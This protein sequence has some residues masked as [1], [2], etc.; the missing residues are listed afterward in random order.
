VCAVAA[1]RT[2]VLGLGNPGARYA[3]TRHN[4]GATFVA[5]AALRWRVAL[6]RACTAADYGIGVVAETPVVLAASRTFVNA[7]GDAVRALG[8]T[9]AAGRLVVV[10][11]DLDLPVGRV[12]MRGAGGSGGHRGVASVIEAIGA[13]FVRVRIGIGRPPEGVAPV[14]FVLGRFT[15]DEEPLL[16]GAF[17]RALEGLHTFL[18]AGLERAMDV[19]N[20]R[21]E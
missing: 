4:V 20:R 1:P 2:L 7:S 21:V 8:E 13:E 15:A 3:G 5:H 18:E 17:A 12:R 6:D 19:A 14:D 16:D 11:D 9:V 10:H